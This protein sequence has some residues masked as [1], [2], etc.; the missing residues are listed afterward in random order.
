MIVWVE[1][2]G[3]RRDFRM[4]ISKAKTELEKPGEAVVCGGLLR[5]WPTLPYK[6]LR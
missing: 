5:A 6:E 1:C 3:K 4:V 2:R